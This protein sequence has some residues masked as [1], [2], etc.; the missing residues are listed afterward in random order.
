MFDP[1]FLGHL[2]A[3]HCPLIRALGPYF[4]GGSPEISSP[5]HKIHGTGIFTFTCTIKNRPFDYLQYMRTIK[6]I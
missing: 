5:S 3:H 2:E 4:L 6:N 1:N